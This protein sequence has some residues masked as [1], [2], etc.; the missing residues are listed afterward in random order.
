MSHYIIIIKVWV[1][2]V[3]DY[4]IYNPYPVIQKWKNEGID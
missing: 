1:I 4:V 3:H 2:I